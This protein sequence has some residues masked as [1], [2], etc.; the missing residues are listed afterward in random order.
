[1]LSLTLS[2]ITNLISAVELWE[3]TISPTDLPM[4]DIVPSVL[5]NEDGTINIDIDALQG[6]YEY[7]YL[8]AVKK[9]KEQGVVL[10]AKLVQEKWRLEEEESRGVQRELFNLGG[11]A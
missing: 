5:T 11:D 6:E 1:M 9:K 8:P 3:R 2:D 10:R 4:D 7:K